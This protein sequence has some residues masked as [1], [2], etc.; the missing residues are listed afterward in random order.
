MS[1]TLYLFSALLLLSAAFVVFRIIV[2]RDYLKHKRLTLVASL[3]QL[4]LWTLYMLGFP[5]LYNPPYWMSVWV[6]DRSVD[7]VMRNAGLV[8]IAVGVAA[9]LAVM[10]HLGFRRSLGR[11]ADVLKQTGL[12]RVTRNPGVLL[13]L[14]L[15][16][17]AVLRWPSWYALGWV[18]LFLIMIH[19]MVITEE[20][21][22]RD[23]FG[24]EYEQYCKHTPRY[25]LLQR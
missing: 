6:D 10:A 11:Q 23:T 12:Y 5:S 20:E 9:A 3:L 2:R 1:L 24:E 13:A 19:T 7:P 25:L 21:H 4:L 18:L 14:P 8:L 15:I 22:L 17:G 16:I